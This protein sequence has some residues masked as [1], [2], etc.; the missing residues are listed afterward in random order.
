MKKYISIFTAVCVV[1]ACLTFSPISPSAVTTECNIYEGQNIN[2]QD[3]SKW[4]Q[5]VQSYLCDC[6]NGLMRF[7]ANALS[8]N[9]LVEYYDYSYNIQKNLKPACELPIFG[10]FYATDSNY[11]I[12]SG[13]SNH[14]ENPSAEVFRIT[15]YDK[16]WKKL[17]SDSL[18]GA[19]TYDPFDSGSASI[20]QNG[21]YLYIRTC[22][23]MFTADSGLNHQ[24]NITLIYNISTGKITDSCTTAE[25][26]GGYASH[27]FNQI[28]RADGSNI[29]AV[30]HGD[31]YPRSLV[32]YREKIDNG[33]FQDDWGNYDMIDLYKFS[34]EVGE[35][36]TGA[37][38]GGFEL[39]D[40]GYLVAFN[41]YYGTETLFTNRR[42][43]YTL[44]RPK[45]DSNVTVNQIT[46]YS[47]DVTASTPH[48]VK[49]SNSKFILLWT[50]EGQVNY[51]ELD[52]YGNQVGSIYKTDGSL[53]DCKPILAGNKLIWYT[54]EEN[55]N[56]FYDI[57]TNNLSAVSKVEINN[58][59]DFEV[60]NATNANNKCTKKCKVCGHTE[61][62]C[63]PDDFSLWWRS[64]T[65]TSGSFSGSPAYR[66]DVDAVFTCM[67][68]S[69][70]TYDA[71]SEYQIQ[72][73]DKNILKY[74]RNKYNIFEF[75]P[76]KEG[77]TE[78]T[79]S[80]KYRPSVTKTVTINVAHSYDNG[81]I[82]KKATETETGLVTF[83]CRECGHQRHEITPKLSPEQPD[84]T[85]PVADP[86]APTDPTTPGGNTD[87][88]TPGG[89][90]EPTAPGT[91]GYTK[92]IIKLNT[93]KAT[94]YVKQ[95][96]N[97]SAIILNSKGKTTYTSNNKKIAKVNAYG[98]VTAVKKGT[99]KITV[100]N[101][102]VKKVFTVTVKNPT[103]NKTKV[104][105]KKGKTF[106]IKIKGKVGT[107]KFTS[108]KKAVASVNSKGKITA[109]KKGKTTITVKTNGISL[110]IKVTVK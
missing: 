91:S 99:A 101:N 83:T 95:Q 100:K 2:S 75:T 19:N 76:L 55:V 85:N 60:Q 8:D 26:R 90:T 102:G 78:L 80:L 36:Y 109:K 61:S 49:I 59:H 74:K 43:I 12:L 25:L 45:N 35:N 40:S 34:G 51:T 65:D 73:A 15:K 44:Y 33:K 3:Y 27:S 39:S 79:I 50:A 70:S 96:T 94:L 110:K 108:A 5:P 30:D 98:R 77:K 87:P 64:G 58:G 72:I 29:V 88:T 66:Y 14:D 46:N 54:W 4:S 105:L 48:L 86:T 103:L 107:A 92:T 9:Y 62:F 18:Y 32:L 42:N 21:D 81:T 1:A 41:S 97:I 16:Q 28:V 13:R 93:S 23:S 104:T 20:Y 22:R 84:A 56:T 89:K 7:Q 71:N 24:S 106:A 82:I 11:Y 63:L 38:L 68:Y 31:A 53:S 52:Q 47:G 37:S 17:S 69:D 67:A 6:G 57:N 10:C